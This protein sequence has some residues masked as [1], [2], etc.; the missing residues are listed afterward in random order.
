MSVRRIASVAL[1]VCALG[2]TGGAIVGG[3]GGAA[4]GLMLGQW[5][6]LVGLAAAGA[7]F[8]GA[9]GLLL[10]PLAGFGA[11]RHVPLWRAVAYT[12]CGALIGIL[13]GMALQVSFLATSLAGFALGAAYARVRHSTRRLA[14][15]S[16]ST[17]L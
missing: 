1:G 3:L 16:T 4:F 17:R 6:D 9:F 11:L 8:G 12:G 7:L 14:S 2:V 13:A 15:G 5:T 10:G